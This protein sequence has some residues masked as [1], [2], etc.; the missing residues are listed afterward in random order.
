[1]EQTKISQ[2]IEDYLSLIYVLERDGEPVIG[3]YLAE[4]LGVSAP[5]VTNT[6][7]RMARDGLIY[8]ESDGPHLTESGWAAACNVMRLHM[9]MGHIF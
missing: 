6:L 7:K 3:A 2:T 4:S 1:M 9:L 5:T 8:L